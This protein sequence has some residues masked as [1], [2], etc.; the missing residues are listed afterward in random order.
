MGIIRCEKHGE[1]GI[2]QVSDR[3]YEAFI[4]EAHFEILEHQ[5]ILDEKP[6]PLLIFYFAFGEVIDWAQAEMNIDYFEEH[7]G[8][9]SG[10]KVVCVN[11][12][13]EYLIKN[14]IKS[15]RRVYSISS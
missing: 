1:S 2:L 3:L 5:F 4:N 15:Y 11:C 7:F 8:T 10:N 14:N 12:W 13:N 9:I 6:D